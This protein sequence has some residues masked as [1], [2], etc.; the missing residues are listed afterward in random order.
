MQLRKFLFAIIFLLLIMFFI[1]SFAEFQDILQ[2]LTSGNWRFLGLALIVQILWFLNVNTSYH[3]IYRAMGIKE[4]RGR[5]F[6]VTTAANFITTIA[7]SAGVT[8]L[9][10]FLSDASRRNHPA[11]KVTVACMIYLLFEYFGLLCAVVLGIVVLFRRGQLEAYEI[12]AAC[13]LGLIAITFV[14]LLVLGMRSPRALGRV[15]SR[16]TRLVNRI[17]GIFSKKEVILP[18]SAYFFADDIATGIDAL[19]KNIKGLIPAAIL[20]LTNKGLLII[21]L[22]LMFL[23]FGVAYTP[24]TVIAG[25]AIGFLFAVISPTPSGIGIVEGVLTLAL[26]TLNVP[27]EAA[28]VLTLG[29]RAYTFWLPFIVGIVTFRILSGSGRKR[30]AIT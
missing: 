28:T 19:R 10:V 17:A 4:T 12:I 30:E 8:A 25:F 13:L 15:V 16:I 11:G 6:L 5:L 22:Y 9:A 26:T 3:S 18:E 20:A 23:A 29:F 7:P 1:G 24:G 21:V 27:L 2:I 14:I